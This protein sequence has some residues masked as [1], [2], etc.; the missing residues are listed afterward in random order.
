MAAG[1]AFHARGFHPT[2]V[3]GVF[4]Q[5]RPPRGSAVSTPSAP[6]TRSG[7]RAAWHR[8]CSS[9][10]PTAPRRN[11]SIRAGLPRPGSRRLGWRRTGRLDRR[12]S[13]RVGSALHAYLRGVDADIAGQV[14]DLGSAGRTPEIAF[15][16]YP[17]VPLRPRTAR[18]AGAARARAR[19]APDDVESIVAIT[20]VTGESLRP[21][22]ARG[23]APAADRLTTA[24]FSLPYCLA[25]LLVH[26]HVDVPSF[27]EDA[28]ADPR[29]LA[30][31][32][33]VRYEVKQ[34]APAPVAFSGER[35]R[36]DP[37]RAGP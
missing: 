4:G 6:H 1:G 29:V 26:G 33:S 21:A 36:R 19:L 13:S 9:S 5:R 24:K 27:T 34:Y 15:K 16:P 14:G 18:F 3:C 20:D 31:A 10:S 28:I 30:V 37:R 25:A 32:A 12:R 7:W 17:A 23:Q 22:P 2:G 11:G 35:F 8:G